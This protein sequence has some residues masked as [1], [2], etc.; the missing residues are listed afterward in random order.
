MPPSSGD[1][2]QTPESR[3]TGGLA[4]VLSTLTGSRSSRGQISPANSHPPIPA[5]NLHLAQQL[6]NS[7]TT[8]GGIYGGPLEYEYLYG[9]LKDGKS[10]EERRAAADSL[11]LALQDYPLSGVCPPDSAISSY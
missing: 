7:S 10:F 6:N 4:R 11:R 9:Q 3:P 1:V 5:A 8:R 2:A